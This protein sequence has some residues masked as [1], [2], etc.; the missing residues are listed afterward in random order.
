[1]IVRKFLFN[2]AFF[3]QSLSQKG[4]VLILGSTL[5]AAPIS[6]ANLDSGP[7]LAADLAPNVRDIF[8]KAETALEKRQYKRYGQYREQLGDYPLAAYLDYEKLSLELHDLPY[9]QVDH[10]LNQHSGSVL[11]QEL[12]ER[13]LY[14]LARKQRWQDF[15]RYA[16]EPLNTASLRCLHVKAQVKTGNKDALSK[17][18]A[19]WNVGKSQPDACDWAFKAWQKAGLMTPELLWDRH[20]KTVQ[21]GKLGLARHLSDKMAPAM[22]KKAAQLQ[23]VHASPA[24]IRKTSRYSEQD[25]YNQQIILHGLKRL[26]RSHPSWAADSFAIYDAQQLFDENER[27]DTIEYIAIRLARRDQLE[28]ALKLLDST[29]HINSQ[30]L[31]EYLARDSLREQNWADLA[32]WIEK[33]PVDDR[34]S[35][36]WRYWQARIAEQSERPEQQAQ[37]QAL[38]R[39][40][41]LERSYFGFLA[42][43]KLKQNYNYAD[44]PVNYDPALVKLI[45]ELPSIQRASELLSL[46]RVNAARREWFHTTKGFNEAQIMAAGELAKRWGWYRKSIQ[47][48]AE[49]RYW[50]DLTLRFPVAYKN[51]IYQ[52]A[53]TVNLDPHMIYAIARQESAFAPDA[54]SRVGAMGLMQLMPATARQTA[55]KV[56]VKYR[57]SELLTPERNIQ[58]GSRY[59]SDLIKRYDGNRILASAAYNA[60]PHRVKRW[61]SESGEE[62]AF[63]IW[64]ETIPFKETRKYVQNILAYSVIY[65]Y[66]LGEERSLLKS[67]EQEQSL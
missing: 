34:N 19:I 33:M 45:S 39:E 46:G 40:L 62:V 37:A 4:R 55:R 52:A 35:E 24:R 67:I 32:D 36:R 20:L 38:Y 22:R 21:K 6:Q 54:R 18:A 30:Q 43:D 28:R 9:E 47:A 16:T 50:D 56:G 57:K 1:M 2:L 5:L 59:I 17:V 64:I 12:T 11:A 66:R 27:I 53:D 3:S 10:Y 31:L 42:A 14:T 8:K 61:R 65:G 63:D 60:G 13:W 29:R 15:N 48:M 26:A 41:A 25:L 51:E 7:N 23:Q 58:L 44:V 49:I